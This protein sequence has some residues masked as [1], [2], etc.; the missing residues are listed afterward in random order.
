VIGQLEKICRAKYA[1]IKSIFC[2]AYSLKKLARVMANDAQVQ[3]INAVHPGVDDVNFTV[4]SNR[5]FHA[6]AKCSLHTILL[7][8]AIRSYGS[9]PYALVRHRLYD[10]YVYSNMI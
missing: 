10:Q 1:V 4:L 6:R 9:L 3:A 5:M 2:S 7:Q 8:V